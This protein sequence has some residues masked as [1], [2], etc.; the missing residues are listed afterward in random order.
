M[1]A[2]A[3][4]VRQPHIRWMVIAALAALCLHGV[5]WFAARVLMGDADAV[6]ETLRQMELAV[7]WM[8]GALV[9]WLMGVPASRLHATLGVLS[10]A[11]LVTLFGSAAAFA[12]LIFVEGAEINAQLLSSFGMLSLVLVIAHLSLAMPAAVVL[13]AIALTRAKAE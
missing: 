13:Q 8:I 6:G 11:L 1:P 9:L 3:L 7:F 10:C 4:T 5:C 12:K 2:T